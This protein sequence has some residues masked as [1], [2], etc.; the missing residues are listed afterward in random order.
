PERERESGRWLVARAAI[1]NEMGVTAGR[2]G[3]FM[4]AKEH[5]D[6]ARRLL[7]SAPRALESKAGRLELARTLILLCSIAS[8]N[9]VE[10]LCESLRPSARWRFGPPPGAGARSAR[11]RP[12]GGSPFPGEGRGQWQ[13]TIDRAIVVIRGL[14]AEE[15]RNPEYRLY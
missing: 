10:S 6:A 15:P 13:A 9:G 2:R 5:H 12:P 1:L 8:R 7:E 11:R 3:A 14:L 4:A